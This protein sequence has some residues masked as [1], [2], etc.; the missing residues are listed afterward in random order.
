MFPNQQVKQLR[1]QGK[2]AEA[3]QVGH[4]ALAA[5]P[6]DVWLKR[7]IAWV[8]YDCAK[9]EVQ[10][11]SNLVKKNRSDAQLVENIRHYSR[12][13]AALRLERPDMAASNLMRLMADVG[14][15]LYF[16]LGWCKWFGVSGFSE[17][18]LQPYETDKI[19]TPCLLTKV[20]RAVFKWRTS[21]SVDS[22][23]DDK[24][25]FSYLN[26]AIQN[27]AEAE[28][29]KIWLQRD[30]ASFYLLTGD[31]DKAREEMR[32]FV[33]Q[34]SRDFWVW[35]GLAEIERGVAPK[36][37]LAYLCK[38]LLCKAPDSFLGKV[39]LQ[40]A[41]SFLENG[42]VSGAIYECLQVADTYQ[43]E[44]WK[45]PEQLEAMMQS[46]WFAPEQ[47]N[48]T[49]TALYK[50]YSGDADLVVYDNLREVEASYLDSFITAKNSQVKAIFAFQENNKTRQILT[51]AP[52]SLETKPE[53]GGS[54]SLK[55]GSD[56]KG[57]QVLGLQKR[58][59]GSLWDSLGTFEGVV[60]HI[61]PG[62]KTGSIFVSRN[63][64]ALASRQIYE[65]L[66]QLDIGSPV[67]VRVAYNP[68]REVYEAWH[69]APLSTTVAS[70]DIK[71]FV[72]DITIHDSGFGF[73]ANDVFVPPHL[74]K[75]NN[76]SDD[77]LVRVLAVY[78][79]KPKSSDFGWTAI[80][81]L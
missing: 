37:E 75:S 1:D 71:E 45:F 58:D 73:L 9:Q 52:W 79:K 72:E 7:A 38:A 26:S 47:A 10:K 16:F 5:A 39:R 68:V 25:I 59:S 15:H 78:K 62:K 28:T 36:L 74:I 33:K 21:N 50:K 60:E 3:L 65:Q 12:S 56:V 63:T 67:Q 64:V 77:D 27:P 69:L 54:Y 6:D 23:E 51:N 42:E 40:L 70:A 8:Y 11:L 43:K 81:V 24:L 49:Q 22:P 18:D 13:Y 19:K 14:E 2:L 80:A 29:N 34:K 44:G 20:A 41:Q 32:H 35:S 61:N 57:L 46:P 31:R 48:Q 17:Q 30:L 4:T 53:S 55:L 76:L 66:A